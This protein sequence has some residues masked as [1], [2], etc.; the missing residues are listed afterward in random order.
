MLQSIL[1]YLD[2][3]SPSLLLLFVLTDKKVMRR[4]D[5]LFWFVV[6]QVLLNGTGDLLEKLKTENLYIYHINCA[7]SFTILSGYF[8]SVLN[9]KKIDW[10]IGTIYLLFLTFLV[11][12]IFTLEN[13]NS[14]NSCSYGIAGFILVTYSFLY[15]LEQI[16]QPTT[17]AI[18]RSKDFW[19]VTAIFTY[20]ASNFF[21]FISYNWL[22][23]EYTTN[24]FAIIWRIHNVIFFIM[25]VYLYIGFKCKPSS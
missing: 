23:Q 12:D 4:R 9:F 13:F 19:Y 20:Y 25:C 22:T 11:I 7:I 8:R 18:T 5:Y 6:V 15:F 24:I 1:K 10:I 16:L 17:T 3:I 14:F 2:F 21:I